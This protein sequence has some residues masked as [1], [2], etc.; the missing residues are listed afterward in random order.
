MDSNCLYCGKAGVL[1]VT[2]QRAVY[3]GNHFKGS[4]VVDVCEECYPKHQKSRKTD[5]SVFFWV[6]LF[7]GSI[8]FLRVFHEVLVEIQ[9]LFR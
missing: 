9:K 2:L 4:E 6:F 5:Y 8:L 7:I 3:G 1:G